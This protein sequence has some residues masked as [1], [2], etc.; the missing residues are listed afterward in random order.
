MLVKSSTDSC[1]IAFRLRLPPQYSVVR[2]TI[3][4]LMR[5][6]CHSTRGGSFSSALSLNMFF[7]ILATEVGGGR[8]RE[9]LFKGKS[10]LK[11]AKVF[12]KSRSCVLKVPPLMLTYG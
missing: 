12:V 3:E 1:L 11:L 9:H 2:L 5:D 8:R 6:D 7:V 10:P 4:V